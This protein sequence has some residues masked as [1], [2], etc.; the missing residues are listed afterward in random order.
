MALGLPIQ[1]GECGKTI[2][3]GHTADISHLAEFSMYD[4]CWTLSLSKWFKPREKTAIALARS[5]LQRGWRTV[6]CVANC[7]G[8]GDNKII[9]IA[10]EERRN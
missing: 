2:L 5:Q 4:W 8:A 9:G 1:N 10:I 7:E 3:Q 6:L